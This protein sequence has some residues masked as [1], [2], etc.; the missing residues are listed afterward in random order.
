MLGW[1]LLSLAASAAWG[2]I[3]ALSDRRVAR[4]WPPEKGGW[5][6]AAW[7]WVL[8]TAIYVGLI[9]AS[10]A[11]WNGLDWPAWLRWG[12]GGAGLTLLSFWVQGRGIVDLGLAGTSGWRV[13]LVTT[14]AYARRRHPQYAGQIVSLVGLGILGGAWSGLVAAAAGSAALLY[15]SIVEDRDLARRHGA[16]HAAYRDRVRMFL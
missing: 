11:D 14:G 1:L 7:A 10:S 4:I 2:A 5:L 6:S 9:N 8:T 15:A 13:G 3:L 12:I 16:S